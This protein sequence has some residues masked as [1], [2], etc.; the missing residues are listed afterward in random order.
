MAS[1][2][3]RVGMLH[4]TW[5]SQLTSVVEPAAEVPGKGAQRHADEQREQHGHDADR[6]RE[7][8]SGHH[9]R[10]VIPSEAVGPQPEGAGV[11]GVFRHPSGVEVDRGSGREHRPFEVLVIGVERRV[12]RHSELVKATQAHRAIQTAPSRAVGSDRKKDR[13]ACTTRN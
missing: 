8:G 7:P 4:I 9:P 2:S 1:T 12:R 13:Q 10:Q 5:S 11:E 3:S 6:E